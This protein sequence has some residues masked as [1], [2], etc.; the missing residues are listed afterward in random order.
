MQYF[1]FSYFHVFTSLKDI[2]I[3]SNLTIPPCVTCKLKDI[4]TLVH[5]LFLTACDNK[6]TIQSSLGISLAQFESLLW[7]ELALLKL[8]ESP[9]D[10]LHIH[11]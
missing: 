4:I 3:F 11:L 2:I 7:D 9:L 6:K 10:W 5:H 8:Y 1:L